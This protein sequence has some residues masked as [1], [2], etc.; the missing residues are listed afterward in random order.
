MRTEKQKQ[1]RSGVQQCQKCSR[2]GHW[3]YECKNEAKYLYRP[4]RM[5]VLR[6][7]EMKI[8]VAAEKAPSW[9][10]VDDGDRYRAPSPESSSED[11]AETK[12]QEEPVINK[13]SIKVPVANEEDSSSSVSVESG[14]ESDSPRQEKKTTQDKGQKSERERSRSRSKDKKDKKAGSPHGDKKR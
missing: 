10:P 9:K 3:T 12:K 7:P 6:N 13:E 8:N 4:S 14:E 1:E 5:T 11:E 2:Y